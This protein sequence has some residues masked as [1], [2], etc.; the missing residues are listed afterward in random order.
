MGLGLVF[1]GM[2]VMGDAMK[3]LRTYEPF[4]ELMTR[5]ENPLLGILVGAVFTGLVQSSAATVGIAIAMASE[6]LLTLPAG[7][8]LALKTADPAIRTV[9]V[10]MARGPAMVESLKAGR[11]VPVVEEPTLADALAGGLIVVTGVVVAAFGW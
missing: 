4:I 3:P 5:M 11:V 1:Y 10:S 7:I 2:G 8:A 6:G 9:G